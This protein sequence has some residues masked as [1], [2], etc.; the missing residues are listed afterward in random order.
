MGRDNRAPLLSP[1][2]ARHNDQLLLLSYTAASAGTSASVDHWGSRDTE[3]QTTNHQPPEE[4]WTLHQ[5]PL[6]HQGLLSG[7][8]PTPPLSRCRSPSP[9]TIEVPPRLVDR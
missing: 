8:P 4:S 3:I 9:D 5:C 2:L 6:H 1:S 7:P